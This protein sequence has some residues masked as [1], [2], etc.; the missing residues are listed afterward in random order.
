MTSV[1]CYRNRFEIPF[2]DLPD[3][4]TLDTAQHS[5]VFDIDDDSPGVLLMTVWTECGRCTPISC[6][7][8]VQTDKL[9]CTRSASAN[10]SSS[11]TVPQTQYVT[12]CNHGS[13]LPIQYIGYCLGLRFRTGELNRRRLPGS[14]NQAQSRGIPY[15]ASDVGPMQ[16]IDVS[17]SQERARCHQS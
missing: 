6:L 3:K 13:I 7:G 9:V 8:A 1:R 2:L 15:G 10:L 4:G 12:T 11:S 5:I 14:V 17:G 16:N